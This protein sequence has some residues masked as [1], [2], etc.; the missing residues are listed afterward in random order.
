M[1]RLRFTFQESLKK[2]LIVKNVEQL[3]SPFSLHTANNFDVRSTLDQT[4]REFLFKSVFQKKPCVDFVE[5][6]V[7]AVRNN[8]VSPALPIHLLSDIFDAVT[9]NESESLFCYV[10][11]NVGEYTIMNL[12]Y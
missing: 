5:L 4:F 9:L 12:H 10:E 8:L 7:Q 1:L 11:D 2:C 3:K 6:S